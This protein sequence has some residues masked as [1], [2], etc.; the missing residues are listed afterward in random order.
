[1]TRFRTARATDGAQPITLGEV[2]LSDAFTTGK[3]TND[4]T[5]I[6]QPTTT[7]SGK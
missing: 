6:F 7:D 2:P 5:T 3:T 4:A 1:M